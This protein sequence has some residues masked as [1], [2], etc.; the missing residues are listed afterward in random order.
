MDLE[1]RSADRRTHRHWRHGALAVSALSLCTTGTLGFAPAAHGATP[2]GAEP[3]ATATSVCSTGSGGSVCVYAETDALKVVFSNIFG[4]IGA[5]SIT[6]EH[7]STVIS[8]S[9]EL[10]GSSTYT[11][12]VPSDQ[13]QGGACGVSILTEKEVCATVNLYVPGS[14]GGYWLSAARGGVFGAGN[15][16]VYGS[17]N[18]SPTSDPVIGIAST[19]NGE[20]Y[21][22]VTRNGTVAHFGDAGNYNDLPGIH[23]VVDDIV[24]IAPTSDGKGYW[25]VGADGG[26]FAFGDAVFH[27]SLPGIHKTVHDIAGMVATPNGHG[28]ILVGNDGGVFVFGGTFHG[29]LPGIHKTVDDIVGILPTGAETGYVLVGA[30]GGAF[31]FGTGS[32]FYG[33][34]P[35][36]AITESDVV[37]IA[38]TPDQKGYWMAGADGSVYN[39]GDASY[40][41]TP[42]GTDSQLPVSAIAGT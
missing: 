16:H 9:I 2:S 13:Y 39:F 28:Y 21:W 36:R 25:L 14:G 19:P 37:G 1:R 8:K 5:V 3:N 35:G 33:S 18:T 42:S 26:E 15:A 17:L 30:D 12:S 20:G 4:G 32:G 7:T 31:V 29:S 38:L 24:A 6:G 34:L 22:E 23:K 27:G 40:F 10:F 41:G 11:A